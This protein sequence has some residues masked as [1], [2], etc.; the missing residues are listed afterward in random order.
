MFNLTFSYHLFF[1]L[2]SDASGLWQ[3][4]MAHL[5]HFCSI[6]NLLQREDGRNTIAKRASEEDEAGVHQR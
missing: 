6:Y 4:I 3:K 2:C 1:N 5:L